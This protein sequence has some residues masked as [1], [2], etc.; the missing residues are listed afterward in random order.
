VVK[1]MLPV[2]FEETEI[3]EIR[4]QAAAEGRS[5]QDYVHDVLMLAITARTQRRREVLDHVLRVSEG[6]NRRLAQ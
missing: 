5:L 2:R 4:A 1:K 3:E 6:L